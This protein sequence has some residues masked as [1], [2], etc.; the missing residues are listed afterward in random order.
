MMKI[1]VRLLVLFAAFGM[2]IQSLA[3]PTLPESG[4]S[5]NVPLPSGPGTPVPGAQVR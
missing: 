5:L 1:S 3:V 4:P 2:G